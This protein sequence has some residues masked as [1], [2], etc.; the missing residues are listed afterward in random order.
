[1]LFNASPV[2]LAVLLPVSLLLF[3][4]A[5]L[6]SWLPARR[7]LEVDPMLALRSE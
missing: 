7:A 1:M 3:G 6:A 2:D 5:L 4:M